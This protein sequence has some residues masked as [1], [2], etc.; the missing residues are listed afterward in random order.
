MLEHS[1]AGS[2]GLVLNNLAPTRIS[3]VA[4][5]LEML[6]CGDPDQHVRLGGPVDQVRGSI[7]HDQADWD[8]AAEAIFSGVYLTTSLEPAIE[9]G[10][11]R[12]G[13]PGTRFQFLLGYAGWGAGQL[14]AEIAAGSWVVVPTTETGDPGVAPDWL[15]RTNT[16]NMWND[17]LQ[18]IGVDPQRLVGLHSGG[19]MLQ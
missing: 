2:T 17:A 16:V 8:P 10:H 7:L 13:Q 1:A 6:W 3:E 15:L 14:E 12:F 11:S 18:S 9:A 4:D 5:S 19:T